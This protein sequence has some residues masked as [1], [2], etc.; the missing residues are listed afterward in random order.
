VSEAGFIEGG[1]TR[2]SE[3][4]RNMC[5]WNDSVNSVMSSFA[6]IFR[7]YSI[8]CALGELTADTI[9]IIVTRA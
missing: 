2:R 3:R 1:A 9:E 8:H 6:R 5:I 7:L 4:L